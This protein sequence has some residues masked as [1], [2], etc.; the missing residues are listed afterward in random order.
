MKAGLVRAVDG[1]NPVNTRASGIATYASTTKTIGGFLSRVELVGVAGSR[2][3]RRPLPEADPGRA[4]AGRGCHGGSVPARA[5]SSARVH[6]HASDR[7]A[8]GRL[9][10]DHRSHG[11]ARTPTSNAWDVPC[12]DERVARRMDPRHLP[13]DDWLSRRPHKAAYDR[14]KSQINHSDDGPLNRVFRLAYRRLVRRQTCVR[15]DSVTGHAD[16]AGHTPDLRRAFAVKVREQEQE[17]AEVA[18]QF[19]GHVADPAMKTCSI[20]P[21]AAESPE[22]SCAAVAA[23]RL[24]RVG[25]RGRW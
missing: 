16:S 6:A 1:P 24:L 12:R 19:F 3:L 9:L 25:V 10:V 7:T 8:K 18:H 22:N 15:S 4:L 17:I 11:S 23:R 20:Q 5:P 14:R 21:D 2:Q 13:T